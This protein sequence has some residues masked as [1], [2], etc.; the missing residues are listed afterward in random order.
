M[1]KSVAVINRVC[2]FA[3]NYLLTK[4]KIMNVSVEHKAEIKRLIKRI[5]PNVYE[6]YDERPY[7]LMVYVKLPNKDWDLSDF[8]SFKLSNLEKVVKGIIKDY[9]NDLYCIDFKWSEDEGE[10]DQFTIYKKDQEILNQFVG[11]AVYSV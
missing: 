8:Y 5:S 6:Y 9:G 2:R 4:T 3:Y 7:E 11:S 1:L 10:F